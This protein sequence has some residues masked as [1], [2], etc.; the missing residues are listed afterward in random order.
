MNRLLRVVRSSVGA[1]YI[2]ALT[3]LGLM[4][5]VIGHMSGNLLIYGGKDAL[6]SYAHGLT[7]HPVLLWTARG[8]LL[9]IFLIHLL[10]A[11]R[12]TQEDQAARPI[13]YVH[14]STIQASWASRHMLLTGF[15]ILGFVIYHLMHF[16]FGIAVDPGHFKSA[17]PQD[18]KQQADVA[19]MVVEGFKQ[20]VIAITYII[21]QIFLGLHLW[22]GGSSWL[23]HLGLNGRGYDKLVNNLGAVVALVVVLGNCSIP[24]V[25]LMG[26]WKPY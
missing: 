21:C 2:M 25:I 14:E 18:P 7:E 11:F 16:T 3:G 20:P 19:Q 6:N 22:H 13:R 17:L 4:I 15:V 1:K 26:W 8:G 10:M 23:Q 9:T 12:L 24:L 5:F